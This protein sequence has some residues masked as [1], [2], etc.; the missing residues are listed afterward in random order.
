MS[1]DH[2]RFVWN[3]VW[4]QLAFFAKFTTTTIDDDACATALK[5]A[6]IDEVVLVAKK[7]GIIK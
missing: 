2:F 1:E 7:W 4:G 6:V 5:P 3:Y